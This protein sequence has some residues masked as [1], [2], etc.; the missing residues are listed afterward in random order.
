MTER[1]AKQEIIEN[2]I[3]LG[4]GDFVDV[5]ALKIAVKA[6][7]E[8][9]AYR[10]IGTV[11]EIQSMKD[12]LLMVREMCKDYYAIGTIE[13]CRTAVERMKPKKPIVQ[14]LGQRYCP[15]CGCGGANYLYCGRCGQKLGE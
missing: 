14:G 3:E 8:I 12:H 1:D 4:A 15:S 10:A 9:Q 6:L 2:G 5:E 7:D 11:E 13:E